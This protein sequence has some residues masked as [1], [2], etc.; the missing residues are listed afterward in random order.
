LRD[1]YREIADLG[2]EVVAIATGDT[3]HARSFVADE[4]IPFPVLVDDDAKAAAAAAVKR[5]W[6]HQLFDPASYPGAR[7]AWRAGHRIGRPGRRTNQLGATFVVGPGSVVH[8]EH[9]DAHTADHAPMEAIFA[10]LR[11]GAN[12]R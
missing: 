6:F 2:A 3:A 7:R 4:R 10:A 1:R 11:A 5:V 9:R 12:A 8:Y